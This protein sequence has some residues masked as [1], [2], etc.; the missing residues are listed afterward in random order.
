MKNL[1]ITLMIGVCAG[2]ADVLPMLLRRSETSLILS[3][4][5][6][7]VVVT[8]F[9]SYIRMPIHP[10]AQGALVAALATLP[11]LITYSQSHPERLP[12]LL[13]IAIVLGGLIGFMT[14]QF[15]R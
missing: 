7:W 13:G 4:F 8:I 1:I 5:V 2:F 15:A 12:V 6:H 10:V 14:N 3:V 9:I 11:I